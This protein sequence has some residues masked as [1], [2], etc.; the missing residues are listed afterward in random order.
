M[1]SLDRRQKVWTKGYYP[2]AIQIL[3]SSAAPATVS[4]KKLRG[5][6]SSSMSLLGLVR[7][8]EETHPGG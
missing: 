6:V 7:R 2:D 1:A 4:T 8:I 5:T 3:S